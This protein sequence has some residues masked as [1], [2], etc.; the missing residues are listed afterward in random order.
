M[1]SL[2]VNIRR[3]LYLIWPKLMQSKNS[4]SEVS[5]KRKGQK[6]TKSKQISA[7][8]DS[9]LGHSIPSSSLV[10][11]AKGKKVKQPKSI[12]SP[13]A[14]ETILEHKHKPTLKELAAIGKELR[15][16]ADT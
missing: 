10:A 15:S 2:Y 9:A 14:D 7:L 11:E 13:L 4:K 3:F 1:C 5:K 12:V 16:K 8:G 6:T